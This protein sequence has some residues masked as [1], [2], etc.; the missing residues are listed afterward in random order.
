MM[1]ALL[2]S[3]MAPDKILAR[4]R[5]VAPGAMHA[6]NCRRRHRI[7]SSR[8]KP[9][10]AGRLTAIFCA[11]VLTACKAAPPVL[12]NHRQPTEADRV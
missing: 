5:Q 7:P 1:G 3:C 11:P 8:G 2:L 6:D 10:S 9:Q 4:M 12:E